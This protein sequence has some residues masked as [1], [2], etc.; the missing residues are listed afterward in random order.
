M[1]GHG[2]IGDVGR[3]DNIVLT[4]SEAVLSTLTAVMPDSGTLAHEQALLGQAGVDLLED[5]LGQ[6]MLLQQMEETQQR[7][8]VRHAL[9]G[10][11][12]TD[13]VAHGLAIVDGIFERLVGKGVLLLK[14]VDPQ[15]ALQADRRAGPTYPPR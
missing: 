5:T 2:D 7:G 4:P 3:G 9:D 14:K 12:D 8:G 13:E 15:Q 6:G 11:I 1:T 10:E